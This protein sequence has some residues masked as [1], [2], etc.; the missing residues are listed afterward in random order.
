MIGILREEAGASVIMDQPPRRKGTS[1]KV[2][3]VSIAGRKRK[4]RMSIGGLFFCMR[5]GSYGRK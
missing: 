2:T 4:S 3:L 5:S 1:E